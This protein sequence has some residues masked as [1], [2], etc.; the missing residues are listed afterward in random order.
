[1]RGG[2][3]IGYR[4]NTVGEVNLGIVGCIEKRRMMIMMMM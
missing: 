4:E 1:M 3:G 2:G